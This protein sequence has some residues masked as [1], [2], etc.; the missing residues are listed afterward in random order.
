MFGHTWSRDQGDEPNDTWVRGLADLSAADLGIGLIA[1]RDSGKA[2]PPGL[3]E[4]RAMCLPNRGMTAME[5]ASHRQF[6]PDRL[7]EDHGAKAAAHEAGE[8]AFAQINKLFGR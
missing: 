7:L 5:S 8:K 1:C 3:P 6:A 4:F 2:F